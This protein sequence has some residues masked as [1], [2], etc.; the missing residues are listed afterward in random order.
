MGPLSP[1]HPATFKLTF[2]TDRG[3]EPKIESADNEIELVAL[4]D[5][6]RRGGFSAAQ[7]LG[8]Y[9]VSVALLL[10]AE[11]TAIRFIRERQS[12]RA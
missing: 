8:G 3:V 1:R 6:A 5:Y 9:V 7:V 12:R 11:R 4:Q 10:L 2:A